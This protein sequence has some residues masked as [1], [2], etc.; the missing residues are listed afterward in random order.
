MVNRQG[1]TSSGS[2]HTP[3]SRTTTTTTTTTTSRT[4]TVL[5]LPVLPRFAA[6]RCPARA[7]HSRS[8]L[9]RSMLYVPTSNP[10]MLLNS[11]TTPADTLIYD[12]EDSVSPSSKSSARTSLSHFLTLNPAP[13]EGGGDTAVRVNAVGTREFED[14]LRAV[15]PHARVN[16]IVLPKVHSPAELDALSSSVPA[17]RELQVVASIES[18]RGMW[19][20]G[21]I[22]GWRA[23]G[24]P[25]LTLSTLL[26]AA[27][28]YCAD[29]GIVRT[30]ARREL[31]Y[32]RA[33]MATAAKAFGLRAIDMVC[34]EYKDE[35]VARAEA[36]EA[37]ELGYDGKQ[38]IHPSQVGV[39]NELFAP[40]Q[41]EVH[42]A[43]LVL[44]GMAHARADAGAGAFSLQ[45]EGRQVMVDEPMVK[46]ARK[47][48]E[49][50][51]AAGM[52]VPHAHP[53]EGDGQI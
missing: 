1:M 22:A 33:R 24:S 7:Y 43:Q 40:S 18:A 6:H 16:T 9:C 28:D 39:Y 8:G 11:L 23:A 46:Q 15:L 52:N 27:E 38:A 12:L 2:S 26:F 50:A 5:K 31:L 29:T 10:R 44:D 49:R 13:R 51:R 47:V 4:M 25:A 53:L 14:D 34:V 17:G 37:K 48:L 20:V 21:A 32:P 30:P 19:G 3:H 45:L 42:R 36:Q 35:E 41:R